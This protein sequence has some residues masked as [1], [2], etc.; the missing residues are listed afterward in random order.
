[1]SKHTP[2]PWFSLNTKDCP[3]VMTDGGFLIVETR[4]INCDA[5]AA[6]IAAAPDMFA[7]LQD[8][9]D[10]WDD[11]NMPMGE[12]LARARA[13]IA[14]SLQRLPSMLQGLL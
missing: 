3:N 6:L 13:A 5:N 12:L 8:I 7:A 10:F 11:P 2:G 9:L 4:G 14:N 1:M